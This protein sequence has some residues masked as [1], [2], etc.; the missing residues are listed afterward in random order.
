MLKMEILREGLVWREK[1]F[2]AEANSIPLLLPLSSWQGSVAVYR[3][4]VKDGSALTASVL[5]Q[6]QWGI[7]S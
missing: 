4:S 5:N 2:P 6:G 7:E 3:V 1:D